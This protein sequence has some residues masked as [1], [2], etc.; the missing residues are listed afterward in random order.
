MTRYIVRRLIQSVFLLIGVATFNFVI[1]HLAPGG[2]ELVSEDPRLPKDYAAQQRRDLGLDQ[3]LPVQYVRW[4]G[5]VARLNFGR[6]FIDKRPVT[7]KIIERMPNT[8]LL[9][10]TSFLVGL[11]GIPLG[12]V[13]ALRRGR[14]ADHG[15]R[16]FA[17]VGNAAPHWWLALIILLISART[18]HWFPLGGTQTIGNGSLFDR[19]H[20]LLLPAVIGGLGGWIGYSRLV[21]SQFLEVMNEDYVR[22]A[23]AKGLADRRVIWSHVL[24]NAMLPVVTSF[25]GILTLALSGSLLFEYT[26]SWPGMGRL[27]FEAASQRDYP[28][29]MALT[30]VSAALVIVGQLL[31]DVLYTFVDPRVKLT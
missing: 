21:R 26:F 19:L 17:A 12:I 31:V 6:S 8:L 18:V 5:Q 22:T 9:S 2:P 7:E 24:R 1:L 15:I 20:H 4:I 29:L 13:A 3:P 11:L 10:G 27:A 25:G 30:V 16:L 28:V 14:A 23:R